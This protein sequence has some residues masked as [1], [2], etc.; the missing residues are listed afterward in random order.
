MTSA[1]LLD[2]LQQALHASIAAVRALV[3]VQPAAKP[4]PRAEGAIER[5]GHPRSGYVVARDASGR[6]DLLTAIVL[7][8]VGLRVTER[9]ER[10]RVEV[11]AQRPYVV[12]VNPASLLD[13]HVGDVRR[14]PS[15][16]QGVRQFD[17]RLLAFAPADKVGMLQALLRPHGSMAAAQ[18]HR[19]LQLRSNLIREHVSEVGGER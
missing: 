6:I 8:D 15:L 13:P 7:D 14:R 2:L 16:R 11:G 12:A 1:C 18:D 10:Q 17:E 9:H 19:H 3:G 5:T 4:R